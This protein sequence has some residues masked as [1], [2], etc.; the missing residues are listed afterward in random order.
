MAWCSFFFSFASKV[1]G[2]IIEMRKKTLI[3]DAKIAGLENRT[4]TKAH[5]VKKAHQSSKTYKTTDFIKDEY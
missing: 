3:S 2:T 5:F 4:S 1:S